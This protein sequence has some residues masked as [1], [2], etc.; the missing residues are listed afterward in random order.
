L[1]GTEKR[2]ERSKRMDN[3]CAQMQKLQKDRAYDGSVLGSETR[4]ER[5][6]RDKGDKRNDVEGM[7]RWGV[8]RG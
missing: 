8:G 6:Q 3:E 2:K 5:S 1:Q 7:N 4:N